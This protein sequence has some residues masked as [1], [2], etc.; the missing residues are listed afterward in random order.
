LVAKGEA[1]GGGKR[2]G[3]ARR[4]ARPRESHSLWAGDSIVGNNQRTAEHRGGDGGRV[5][6]GNGAIG[7]GGDAVPARVVLTELVSGGTRQRDACDVERGR[8]AVGEDERLRRTRGAH[9]HAAKALA[10]GGDRD[11][12]SDPRSRQTHG[13]RAAGGIGLHRH[14]GDGAKDAG[15]KIADGDL[16]TAGGVKAGPAIVGLDKLMRVG[17]GEPDAGDGERHTAKVGER[18]RDHLTGNARGLKGKGDAGGG[19][20]Y[21]RLARPG[22]REAHGMRTAGSVVDDGERGGRG[23]SHR[24]YEADLDQ[25]IGRDGQDGAAGIGLGELVRV[26]P[27]EADAGDVERGRP[28]GVG[29]RDCLCRAGRAYRLV[30]AELEV[31]R[32]QRDSGSN[33]CPRQGHVI[34]AAGGVVGKPQGGARDGASDGGSV[35]DGNGTTGSDV[36]A[37]AA[38]VVGGELVGVRPPD[39]DAG[40][41]ERPRTGVGERNR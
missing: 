20:A 5:G 29:E 27:G 37:R 22:S 25:T 36:Q 13:I 21:R 7:S 4:R 16:A 3:R 1:V 38:R 33:R 12:G 19:Q 11:Q 14:R 2:D 17:T 28:A 18:D 32:E 24:G 39:T 30:G 31:G 15:G 9:H 8:A 35:G 40:D 10:S 41:A 34:R 26:R 23:S 6:D